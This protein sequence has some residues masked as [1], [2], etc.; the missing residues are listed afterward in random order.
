M[1]V[2][3]FRSAI[4]LAIAIAVLPAM[5]A[6][7]PTY[8]DDIKPLLREHCLAVTTSMRPTRISISRPTPAC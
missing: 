3:F 1:A 6:A 5:A 4:T 8:D 7:A 2:F